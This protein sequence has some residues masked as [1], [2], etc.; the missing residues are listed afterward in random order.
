MEQHQSLEQILQQL[1]ERSDDFD[2]FDIQIPEVMSVTAPS[3]ES[4][5]MPSV[6]ALI[7][8]CDGNPTAIRLDVAEALLNDGILQ[9][10]NIPIRLNQLRQRR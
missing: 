8:R 6:A 3:G 9:K 10:L 1:R 2:S 4:M 7:Q 5:P